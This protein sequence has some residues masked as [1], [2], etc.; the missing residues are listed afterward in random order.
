MAH[1]MA[2]LD[3]GFSIG[4]KFRPVFGNRR[5]EVEFAAVGQE[6]GGQRSHGLRGRID[7]DDRVLFPGPRLLD[8]GMAT[9]EV[10]D[11]FAILGDA[12]GRANVC[13]RVQ[14]RLELVPHAFE[15]IVHESLHLG[16]RHAHFLPGL[17]S[18]QTL[19]G[20]LINGNGKIATCSHRVA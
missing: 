6:E 7:V 3:V 10:D 5:I 17:L 14:M 1:Q 15:F 4:G 8:I 11:G 19:R 13:A 2:D 20:H 12:E 16:L 18:A 9:P